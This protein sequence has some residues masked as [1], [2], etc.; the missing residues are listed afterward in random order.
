METRHA[1]VRSLIEAAR[2]NSS[3]LGDRLLA[4]F[5]A[6]NHP[7]DFVAGL[8]AA[9]G[10]VEPAG[11]GG[12]GVAVWQETAL[13]ACS[14]TRP[15]V[16][17]L[18]RREPREMRPVPG[19][20][21]WCRL[22]T[23]KIGSLNT[24][25]IGIAGDWAPSGDF[26]AYNRLSYEL[27]EVPRGVLSQRR[28]V[29]SA[30]YAG[31]VTHYWVY[32]NSGI[33]EERGAPLMVWHD[34]SGYLEPGDAFAMRM[35][36]VTDNLAHIGL[37]PPL[38]HVLVDPS[39]GGEGTE[40][41]IGERYGSTMRGVQY[42]TFSERYG[43][44]IVDEVLPDVQQLVKLR[45]DAYSRGTAGSSSGAVCAFKL[46]WFRPDQFSRVHSTIGSYAGI[47]WADEPEVPPGFM[48]PHLVRREPRRNI[49]VWMS[50]GMNDFEMDGTIEAANELFVAGSWPLSNI[51]LA[52]ALKGRG[53][54]FHFR[55]GEGFHT[56]GQ[57][58]VDLPESLAWLWR[59][60]DPDRTKEVFE[61]EE[62]ERIEPVFRVRVAN[63]EAR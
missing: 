50:D 22:E 15:P 54:D 2:A 36:T 40:F 8:R 18:N 53:Y 7:L 14:S 34:G 47:R 33:D 41:R 19:T 9:Y 62:A 12:S 45:T 43:A 57:A 31:A 17:S 5:P 6:L 60:Y 10:S 55:Y 11:L 1:P 35:Q 56:D 61:Q 20:T 24:Y 59:G 39:T 3:D 52:N 26:A 27:P 37:V 51:M 30:I 63:G 29:E 13:L 38:V 48:V 16:V 4:A 58:A 21:F 44:H 23:V 25:R 42:D 49:R 46:A 28:A 32:A